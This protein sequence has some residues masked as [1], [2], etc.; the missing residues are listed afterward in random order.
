MKATLRYTG[1]AVILHRNTKDDKAISRHVSKQKN[2]N[3]KNS[4]DANEKKTSQFAREAA[5]YLEF[6]VSY[7]CK[8]MMKLVIPMYKPSGRLRFFAPP[9][10]T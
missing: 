1:T 8:M 6:S 2:M 7:F 5:D 9:P 3:I 4:T 10:M